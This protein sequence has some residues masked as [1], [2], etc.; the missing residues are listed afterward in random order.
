LVVQ[1]NEQ[2]I[3]VTGREQL[4]TA[5]KG[6]PKDHPRVELL[7]NK[8]LH[9]WQEWPFGTWLSTSKV[10]DRVTESLRAT[11]PLMQWL[12]KNVGASELEPD[13]R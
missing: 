5:P 1:L 10:V 7:R 6:Y 11:K 13:R 4:K 12:N 3:D 9:S 2:G 8:G